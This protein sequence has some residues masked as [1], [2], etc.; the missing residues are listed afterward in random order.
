MDRLFYNNK[1]DAMYLIIYK[2]GNGI[3]SN[4]W[5][6]IEIKNYKKSLKSCKNNFIIDC[7]A[8][9]IL[10]ECNEKEFRKEI[11]MN[12]LLTYQGI[13][14]DYLNYNLGGFIHENTKIIINEV[15]DTS[16]EKM[17]EILKFNFD[18]IYKKDIIDQIENSIKYV[19]LCNYIHADI[20][21]DNFLVCDLNEKQTNIL[22]YAKNYNYNSM[23]INKKKISNIE[24]ELN[25]LINKI[26]EEFEI[27]DNDLISYDEE[28]SYNTDNSNNSDISDNSDNSNNSDNCDNSY[29]S[30]S[31]NASSFNSELDEFN[32]EYDKFHI[33]KIDVFLNEL[34]NKQ[35]DEIIENEIIENDNIKEF[36]LN[37]LKN[38]KIKL[39][40]FGLI[41]KPGALD[42][43][44]TRCFRSPYNIMGYCCDYYDD[45]WALEMM[46][47][48]LYNGKI[49]IDI[50]KDKNYN[51]YNNNLLCIKNILNKKKI[52]F[53]EIEKSKR[54]NSVFSSDKS[55]LFK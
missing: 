15:M 23:F 50:R 22:K 21:L 43:I 48:E 42:T 47:Y 35:N 46:K 4:V 12:E 7:K 33:K 38:I 39:N 25:I 2:L 52:N 41:K 45:L 10:N 40:D 49:L 18:E 26:I 24:N 29:E 32:I 13:K 6:S 20:K 16:L 55:F 9:K 1:N 19:H 36:Y 8:L 17:C 44:N 54:I 31:T 3:S 51:I 11:Q 34:E 30:Y 14:S 28:L 37:K 53:S 27:D 5:Y